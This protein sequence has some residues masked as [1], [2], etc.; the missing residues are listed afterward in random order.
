M[1]SG[2]S[3]QTAFGVRVQ[4]PKKTSL[5]YYVGIS[6]LCA[7]GPK[8][9]LG[10]IPTLSLLSTSKNQILLNPEGFPPQCLLKTRKEISQMRASQ[11]LREMTRV[12]GEG[13]QHPKVVIFKATTSGYH[14]FWCT[15]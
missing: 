11:K 2:S 1:F 9:I 4:S 12:L 6:Y 7:T 15:C 13:T 5:S 8:R 10:M 3:F 14:M